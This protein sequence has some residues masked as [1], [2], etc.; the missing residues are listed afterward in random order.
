MPDSPIRSVDLNKI[1]HG[2]MFEGSRGTLVADFTTRL[3]IPTGDKADFTYCKRRTTETI[4]P[5]MGGFQEQW[6]DACKGDLKTACD[7]E[8]SA[9]MIETMLLG[10]VAYRA[11]RK[12]SYDNHGGPGT[13][14]DKANASEQEYR[15][16]WTMDG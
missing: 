16:G 2:A 12:L 13:N 11:G 1:D 3:L 14:D 6:L 9:N 7:F 10:L 4:I 8:Y 5:P 15:D